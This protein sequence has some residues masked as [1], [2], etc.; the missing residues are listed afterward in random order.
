[1]RSVVTGHD[2]SHDR[3]YTIVGISRA[4][5]RTTSLK[6]VAFVRSQWQI[7][8]EIGDWSFLC[9]FLHKLCDP[10][11][12][13]SSVTG[14]LEETL[15]EPGLDSA[16]ERCNFET[17]L[18]CDALANHWRKNISLVITTLDLLEIALTV[19]WKSLGVR[20]NRTAV[21]GDYFLRLIF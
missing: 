16:T 2:G 21:N 1:M 4:T 10:M 8:K 11:I 18:Y 6:T 3:S 7:V 14:A 12:V 15:P 5:S 20:W 17:R 19:C 13:R 9:R